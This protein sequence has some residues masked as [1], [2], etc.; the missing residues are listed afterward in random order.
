[1]TKYEEFLSRKNITRKEFLPIWK[2]FK[3]ELNRGTVRVA[4]KDETGTWQINRW[5]KSFILLGFQY[6]ELRKFEDG[7]IDKDTL[8]ERKIELE[9]KIRTVSPT[10]SI[11]DGVYLGKGVT[12]MPPCYANIGA[13]IE[14]GSMLDSLVL[15]GSCAQIGKNVH[16]GARNCY[17]WSYRACWSISCDRRGS[18]LYWS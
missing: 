3:K 4:Q 8:G 16:I 17:W 11:R 13:Y 7:S 6:G 9:E 2:E 15:V 1:M 12:C 18:S 10:I 5:V 14:E